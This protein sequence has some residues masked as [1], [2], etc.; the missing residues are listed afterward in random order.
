MQAILYV[1]HGTRKRSGRKEVYSSLAPVIKKVNSPLQK[2]CFLQFSRPTLLEG[3]EMCVKEGA[4][5]IIIVPLLLLKADHAT[6]DIPQAIIS[7]R[8]K[9]PFIQ[10]I[11]EE[12]L[13]EEEKLIDALYE[14][15]VMKQFLEVP[16]RHVLLV[17]RG[18]RSP[19]VKQHLIQVSERLQ[20]KLPETEMTICFLYGHKPH[21]QDIVNEAT[22]KQRFILPF[23]LFDGRLF[24]SLT[25]AAKKKGWILCDT[26]G[27]SA[28]V[29]DIVTKRINRWLT[30]KEKERGE[31]YVI[32]NDK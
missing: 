21:F 4:T 22:E 5:T 32:T 15:L 25:Q 8:R 24:A 29:R 7:A 28:H 18:G 27:S 30:D 19:Q 9:Y 20:R 23:L 26:L 17:G 13:G 3:I 12:P 11:Y 31:V 6:Y 16:Q 10:F 1:S 14:A 2:I